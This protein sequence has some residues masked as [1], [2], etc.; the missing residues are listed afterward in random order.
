I[1]SNPLDNLAKNNA[2]SRKCGK[3]SL[4]CFKYSSLFV[5]IILDSSPLRQTL[6]IVPFGLC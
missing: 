1:S 3:E 4:I 5:S 2:L 6:S